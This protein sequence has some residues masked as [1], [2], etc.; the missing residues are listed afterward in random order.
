MQYARL[1]SNPLEAVAS[2]LGGRALGLAVDTSG[3]T[4]RPRTV[5]LGADAIR[6]SA[7]A[8][9]A[10]LGGAGSWLLALPAERIGGAMVV[11]RAAIA[12]TRVNHLPQ[13]PFT[14]EAFARA[15]D[16]LAHDSGGPQYVSLVPTQLG[17]LLA[18]HAGRDALSAF[19]AILVGGAPLRG[20]RDALPVIETYGSTET[21]GGCVYDGVALDGVEFGLDH[22]RVRV[23]GPTLAAGYEDGDNTA[24]TTIAGVRWVTMPDVGRIEGGRLVVAGRAD[25]VIV[26]GGYKVHPEAVERALATTV[27]TLDGVVVGVPDREWGERVVVVAAGY[28]GSAEALRALLRDRLPAHAL[29]RDVVYVDALPLGVGG[30]IDRTAARSL[31]RRQP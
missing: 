2:V 23:S 15:T 25:E 6:A 31:A 21:C 22:E 7:A 8:T 16:A 28:R 14:A 26:T 19:R 9:H 13:G 20:E 27:P 1:E 30:K 17:R 24:F 18:T 10:R 12:D 11:A 3:S 29:P 5:L 4:G